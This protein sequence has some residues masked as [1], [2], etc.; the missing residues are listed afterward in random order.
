MLIRVEDMI[1]SYVELH[2][3]FRRDAQLDRVQFEEPHYVIVERRQRQLGHQIHSIGDP[4]RV[5]NETVVR[6][7]ELRITRLRAGI[8]VTRGVIER[9]RGVG[10]GV[11]REE[12][13]KRTSEAVSAYG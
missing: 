11:Q 12:S 1:T 5:W 2:Q 4:R 10:G 3:D 6:A 13:R 8:G 7:D 9:G